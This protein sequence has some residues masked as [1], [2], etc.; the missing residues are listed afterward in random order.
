MQ[1][2]ALTTANCSARS[3]G[4]RRGGMPLF[5]S[6]SSPTGSLHHLR[7]GQAQ[8]CSLSFEGQQ[9][10]RHVVA[11]ERRPPAPPCWLAARGQRDSHLGRPSIHLR[12]S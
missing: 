12:T 10:S 2:A 6:S 1:F 9:Q 5:A 4:S 11:S 7:T 3:L 8:E